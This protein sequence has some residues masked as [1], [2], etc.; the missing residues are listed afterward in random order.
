MTPDESRTMLDLY[1]LFVRKDRPAGLSENSWRLSAFGAV[2]AGFWPELGE[3]TDEDA[4]A[5]G[6]TLIAAMKL[7]GEAI[8]TP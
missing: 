8:P 7:Y 6:L 5:R 2:A 1:H 4:E 3:P